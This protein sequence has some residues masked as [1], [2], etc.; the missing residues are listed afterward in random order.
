MTKLEF[1]ARISSD[2]VFTHFWCVNNRKEISRELLRYLA[3]VKT[4]PYPFVPL[5]N[6]CCN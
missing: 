4:S 6:S 1:F 3:E 2:M 5:S